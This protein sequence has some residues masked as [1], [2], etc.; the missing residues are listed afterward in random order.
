MVMVAIKVERCFLSGG[1]GGYKG[2]GM[3]IEG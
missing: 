2:R 3:W 1:D